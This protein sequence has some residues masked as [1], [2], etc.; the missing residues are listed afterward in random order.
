MSVL[1]VRPDKT[2]FVWIVIQTE[3]G[4]TNYWIYA[5]MKAQPRVKSKKKLVSEVNRMKVP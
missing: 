5:P 1:V 4:G 3:Y 2:P